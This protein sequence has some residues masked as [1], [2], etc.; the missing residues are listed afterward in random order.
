MFDSELFDNLHAPRFLAASEIPAETLDELADVWDAIGPHT[1]FDHDECAT[2]F[3]EHY[4]W[5]WWS[6]SRDMDDDGNY[7]DDVPLWT[8]KNWRSF[9]PSYESPID[10]ANSRV[11]ETELYEYGR[12]D[13]T[14][15][16]YGWN[17]DCVRGGVLTT[18]G[19]V[20]CALEMRMADY[21]VLDDGI[22]YTVEDEWK[23]QTFSDIWYSYSLNHDVDGVDMDDVYVKW[24]ETGEADYEGVNLTDDLLDEFVAAV[25]ADSDEEVKRNA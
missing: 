18:A 13:Y 9:Y 4:P 6:E 23:H 1:R 19:V 3:K 2:W 20:V 16:G 5:Q 24:D 11:A 14:N 7:M 15:S 8:L 10:E 25:K 17:V 22:W 12:G 21:P